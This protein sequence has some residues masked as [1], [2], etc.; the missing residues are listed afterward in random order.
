MAENVSKAIIYFGYPITIR[1]GVSE[2]QHLSM[3]ITSK[4]GENDEL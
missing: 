1:A 2:Q 4:I 3:A